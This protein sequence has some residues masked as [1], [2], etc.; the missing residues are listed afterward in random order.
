M[1]GTVALILGIALTGCGLLPPPDAG[2]P[3]GDVDTA[4]RQIRTGGPASAPNGPAVEILRGR[5][6]ELLSVVVQRD[7]V[8]VCMG[9]S[10]GAHGGE[11]CSPVPAGGP[12]DPFGG[13]STGGGDG[14]VF[15]IAGISA[16]DVAS[17]VVEIEDGSV[18]RALIVSLEPAGIGA[19][20]FFVYLRDLVPHSLVA[21]ADDG[22]ELGRLTI[23]APILP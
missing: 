23:V 1:R 16:L 9:I 22:S 21:L 5:I 3:I 20:A 17:V 2:I 8:G 11:T 6:D 19:N 4:A 15:E 13:V 14:A 18:A 12:Q 7:A 10:R